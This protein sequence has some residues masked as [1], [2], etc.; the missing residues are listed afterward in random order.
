[1]FLGYMFLLSHMNAHK[2]LHS[3]SFAINMVHGMSSQSS[4]TCTVLV[5]EHLYSPHVAIRKWKGFVLGPFEGPFF[6]VVGGPIW[7]P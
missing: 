7:G 1:M 4:Y 6:R 3:N 2:Y 5:H